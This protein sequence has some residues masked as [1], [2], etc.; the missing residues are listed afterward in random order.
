M[1]NLVS[2]VANKGYHYRPRLVKG[3]VDHE[4]NVIETF[5]PEIY[6]TVPKEL[7]SDKTYDVIHEIMNSVTKSSPRRGTSA[8]A[9]SG[10]PIEVAAKTGTSQV[11]GKGDHAW[12]VGF[13]PLEKPEIAVVV[14][15]EHGDMHGW[16][17]QIARRIMDYYFGL[18]ND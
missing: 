16:T 6:R 7:V 1:A 17:G 15:I 10:F 5:E 11:G 8:T 14:F 3:V 12:W 13:A 18:V 2:I 9:F 4:G